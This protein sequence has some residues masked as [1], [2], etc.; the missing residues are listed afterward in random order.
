MVLQ[1]GE[2]SNNGLITPYFYLARHLARHKLNGRKDNFRK[3]DPTDGQDSVEW[4]Y[5][6][7]YDT[8]NSNWRIAVDGLPAPRWT[9]SLS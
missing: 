2:R 9:I 8:V 7:L 5:P 1:S 4:T 3:S 6:V